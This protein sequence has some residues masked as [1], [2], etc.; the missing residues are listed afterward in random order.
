[1]T[2]LFGKQ[3]PRDRLITFYYWLQQLL[4]A[5]SSSS[6]IFFVS[7]VS[8]F[9]L[10]DVYMSIQSC[11]I[12]C[13][14]HFFPCNLAD[15]GIQFNSVYTRALKSSRW[16]PSSALRSSAWYALFLWSL[17]QRH[18]LFSATFTAISFLTMNCRLKL[19]NQNKEQFVPV[20]VLFF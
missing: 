7:F 11:A 6:S 18:K 13:I 15:T 16:L 20:R 19:K 14:L 3:H 2:M 5:Q 1:M 12:D 17:L 8:S 4:Q 10:I 9:F